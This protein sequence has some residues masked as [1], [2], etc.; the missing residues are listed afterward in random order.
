MTRRCLV[1]IAVLTVGFMAVQAAAHDSYRIVGVVTQRQDTQISVKSRDGKT[2]AIG[3]NKQTEV[4]RNKK[5]VDASEVKVGASVVV[6]ALG[7]SEADLLAV[8]V[9]LVPPMDQPKK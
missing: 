7:D 5:K 8:E 1:L 6:E 9:Q 2:T 4:T 3:M